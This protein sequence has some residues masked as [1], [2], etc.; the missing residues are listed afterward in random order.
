MERVGDWMQTATGKKFW[1]LDPRP[2]DVDVTDIAYALSKIC[3]YGGHCLDFYS[4]AEHSVLVAQAAPK[5][6][7]I[8][9]LLHDA[10]EAYL[11]D[12]IRPLKRF[13]PGYAEME[14]RVAAA[15]AAHFGLENLHDPIV[16]E[17]DNNII[18]DE[19]HQAMWRGPAWDN[20]AW[21]IG[22]EELGV[23]LHF[24]KPHTAA[25]KFLEAYVDFGGT[26][27]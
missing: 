25:A 6:L 5:P 26:L 22:R 3:R 27:S 4:V 24:W 12:V 1:P 20:P 19:H 8:K 13:I 17:I 18:L 9:A 15:I 23:T 10:T 16:K 2:E 14:A 7:R 21:E 11:G